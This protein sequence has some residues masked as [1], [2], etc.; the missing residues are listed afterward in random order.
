M[1]PI[2]SI[3]VPVFNAQT[4]L[5]QA[6][7]SILAQSLPNFELI[8]VN[9]GSTDSSAQMLVDAKAKD[10]RVRVFEQKNIGETGAR[11]RGLEEVRG[12]YFT[13]VDADDVLHP[14]FLKLLYQQ[15]EKH[16]ADL[17]GCNLVYFEQ[18]DQPMFQLG[19]REVDHCVTGVESL[20]SFFLDEV[21]PSACSRL[22][23][24]QTFID[25]RFVEGMTCAGD[26]L[27]SYQCF[28][29][30]RKLQMMEAVLYGYRQHASSVMGS[31]KHQK[32]I[33]V[34]YV[35]QSIY[36]Q[37]KLKPWFFEL[38]TFLD[39]FLINHTLNYR[40]SELLNAPYYDWAACD[41]IRQT[42]QKSFGMT[43]ARLEKAMAAKL[44]FKTTMIF[45]GPAWLAK[46]L[47]FYKYKRH[48]AKLNKT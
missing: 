34:L 43:K 35:M 26:A 15:A 11:N 1:N 7:D 23:H 4:Y 39:V 45:L 9:D 29:R 24:T 32:I 18:N 12:M 17:I 19:F 8:M 16:K 36:T 31:Y 13:F 38:R 41:A 14:D 10:S 21:K 6:I 2:I 30:V 42:V 46:C 37:A 3:I 44:D 28:L 27:Y 5:V 40:Y 22:Y 47:F 33:D 25:I 20:K 48:Q